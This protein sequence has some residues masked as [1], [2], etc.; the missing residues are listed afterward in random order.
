MSLDY[1][2]MEWVKKQPNCPSN[3]KLTWA[4]GLGGLVVGGIWLLFDMADLHLKL[5]GLHHS[6]LWQFWWLNATVGLANGVHMVSFFW[7]ME[8]AEDGSVM[9]GILQGARMVIVILHGA[10]FL[11]EQQLSQ[12]MSPFKGLSI[13][14]VTVSICV[15]LLAKHIATHFQR[16]CRWA[17]YSIAGSSNPHATKDH[18]KQPLIAM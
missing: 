10:L 2:A 3:V 8:W 4:T 6:K 12:C 11:C 1:V 15:F 7:L 18:E 16:S 14:I 5:D 17:T 9:I 13:G